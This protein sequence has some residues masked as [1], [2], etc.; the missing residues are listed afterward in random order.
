MKPIAV[1]LYSVRELF[2]KDIPGT[3]AAMAEIGFKGVEMAGMRGHKPQDVAAV[4]RDLGLKACSAHIGL[5]TAET[6]DQEVEVART[7]GYDLLV[8]NRKAEHFATLDA[9]KATAEALQNAH[10]LARRNGLRMGYHNHDFEFDPLAGRTGMEILLE[11]APDIIWQVDTCHAAN[12]GAID[13]PAFM[14]RYA[15]RIRSIHCKDSLLARG[16]EKYTAV[17]KGKVDI[18]GCVQAGDAAKV[19]WL[20]VELDACATDMMQA[21]RDS[22]DFL[23]GRGLAKGNR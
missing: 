10:E 21:V 16:D 6:I 3:L 1:Q 17:G 11:L 22:Y 2:Q 19:E 13:V 23:T 14:K 9:V 18:V 15:G 12:F 5:P 7:L 8:T 4:C 20:I